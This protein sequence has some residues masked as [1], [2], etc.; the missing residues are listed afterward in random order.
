VGKMN[1]AGKI[2]VKQSLPGHAAAESPVPDESATLTQP[3]PSHRLPLSVL[4]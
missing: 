2:A 1:L 4:D 3:P